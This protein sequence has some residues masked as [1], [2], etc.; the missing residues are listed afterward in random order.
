MT[1]S[2]PKPPQR[3]VLDD[4]SWRYVEARSLDAFTGS[5]WA[6]LDR[7]RASFYARH[8]ANEVLRMLSASEKD[9]VFGYC[10]NNYRHCLQ[11]ASM[12]L[13]AGEDEETVV[14]AL[15]HDI[16]FIACPATHGA[17]AAA[18]LAAY[19]DER[20]HWMLT[21]H[22]AFQSYHCATHPDCD[23]N[24]RERWRGHP[25]FAWTAR[26]VERYDQNAIDPD[27]ENLP[28]STFEPMVR[29]LFARPPRPIANTG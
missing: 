14:V 23:A 25:H 3:S 13:R 7:Q 12:A 28:L 6:L 8:Q 20:H 27:Y 11:A 2:A 1:S 18:L 5:D 9:P 26:F 29:R 22:Q 4:P 21:H 15:L 10:I 16:G 19:V 17:F 24:E